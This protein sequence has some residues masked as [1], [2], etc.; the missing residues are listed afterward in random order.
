MAIT[1]GCQAPPTTTLQQNIDPLLGVKVPPGPVGPPSN[2]PTTASLWQAPP[3]LGGAPANAVSPTSANTA[4]MAGASSQSPL[5]QPTPIND[6]NARPPFLPGQT[7]TVNAPLAPGAALPN[8][9]PKVEPVPDTAPSAPPAVA[10][11]A[12]WQPTP[13]SQPVVQTASVAAPDYAKLLQDRGVRD[14]KVDQVP[15]GVRLTCYLP[16]DASGR[17][18]IRY[19][20]A[21]DYVTAVQAMLHDLDQP[22]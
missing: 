9:N 21:K 2:A 10:P 16:P 1:T 8:P 18:N 17:P 7:Q 5:G 11:I 12:N 14:Q 6:P 22:R 19:V 13:G 3:A 15:E 20:T 4:T